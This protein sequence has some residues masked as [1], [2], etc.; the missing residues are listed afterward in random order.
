MKRKLSMTLL[1]LFLCA[2]LVIAAGDAAD[3]L[4]SLSYLN[5][6]YTQQLDSAIEE[7]LAGKTSR[8]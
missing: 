3:P 7:Y 2:G 4:V 5:S 8:H 1:C 6:T